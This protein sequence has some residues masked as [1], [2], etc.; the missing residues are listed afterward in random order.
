MPYRKL[1]HLPTIIKIPDKSWNEIKLLLPPEKPNDTI[2][3]SA[4]PFRRVLH[5]MVSYTF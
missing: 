3:R 1:K 5:G 2:G 4:T